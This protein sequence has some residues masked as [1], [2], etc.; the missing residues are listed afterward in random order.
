MEGLG[1]FLGEELGF[2]FIT[3]CEQM[4]CSWSGAC[5]GDCLGEAVN[6]FCCVFDHRYLCNPGLGE[7][8][9]HSKVVMNWSMADNKAIA[10]YCGKIGYKLGDLERVNSM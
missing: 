4:V 8:K 7:I 9:F 2:L 3:D 6:D 1:L 10:I 5:S